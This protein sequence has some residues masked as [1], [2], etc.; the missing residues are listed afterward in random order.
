MATATR[1]GGFRPD[2]Y[3]P[4]A[5]DADNDGIVQEGTLFERPVGTRFINLDGTELAEM[6]S[7]TN[8][9]D[10]SGLKIVDRDGKTVDYKPSWSQGVLSIGQRF[11]SLEDRGLLSIGQLTGAVAPPKKAKKI[12]AKVSEITQTFSDSELAELR[13]LYPEIFDNEGNLIRPF[14][15]MERVYGFEGEAK[16]LIRG[17]KTWSDVREALRG[18]TII[19]YDYETT[20][21][22]SEGGRSVQ[23]GAVKIVDG[24]VVDRINIYMDPGI[25]HSQWSEFSRNNLRNAD[26]EIITPDMVA[27]WPSTQQ[28]HQ[29]FVDW[30][31][32]GEFYTMGHNAFTFDDRLQE[33]ELNSAGIEGFN[34]AGRLDTLSISRDLIDTKA[35][36][37]ISKRHT[38]GALAEA[39]GIELGDKA[40][41]ADAD[42]EATG[43]LLYALLDYAEDRDLPVDLIEPNKNEPR[44]QQM[45]EKYQEDKARY[46][47]LSRVYS[48]VQKSIDDRKRIQRESERMGVTPRPS[49]PQLVDETED[50]VNPEGMKPVRKS[51]DDIISGVDDGTISVSKV[52]DKSNLTIN[53]HG[54]DVEVPLY[55]DENGEIAE[56]SEEG[57]ELLDN[58]SKAGRSIRTRAQRL[59]MGTQEGKDILRNQDVLNSEERKRSLALTEAMNKSDKLTIDTAS[60]ILGRD[61]LSLDDLDDS[62]RSIILS[63]LNTDLT[64]DSQS[65]RLSQELREATQAYNEVMEQKYI[66]LMRIRALQKKAIVQI[67]YGRPN[68]DDGYTRRGNPDIEIPSTYR[69]FLPRS[70]SKEDR[71]LLQRRSQESIDDSIRYAMTLL[72]ESWQSRLIEEIGGTGSGKLQVRVFSPD[73]PRLGGAHAMFYK[74][75]DGSYIIAVSSNLT[76]PQ[77]PTQRRALRRVVGHE[78]MHA[79]EDAVPELAVVRDALFTKR[80]RETGVAGLR[81][82][83]DVSLMLDDDFSDTY[84]GVIYAGDD[85]HSEIFTTGFE[86]IFLPAETQLDVPAPDQ[87][88]SDIVLGV[89]ASISGKDR[90]G[91]LRERR[92]KNTPAANTPGD[93]PTPKLSPTVS[94]QDDR[95]S[96]IPDRSGKPLNISVPGSSEYYGV[97]PVGADGFGNPKH[98]ELSTFGAD[99]GQTIRGVPIDPDDPSIP[100]IL[101]H[102]SVD[103]PSVRREGTLRARGA[104]GLGGDSND[105]IVSMTVSSETAQQLESDM[106]LMTQI[107]RNVDNPDEYIRLLKDDMSKYGA[108]MS[109]KQ[110]GQIRAALESDPSGAYRMYFVTRESVGSKPRDPMFT[111]NATER[112]AEMDPDSIGI[113]QIPKENLKTGA[114]VTNFDVGEG[115]LDEIRIY[116]DVNTAGLEDVSLEDLREDPETVPVDQ[117]AKQI[118]D[119]DRALNNP[120]LDTPLLSDEGFVAMVQRIRQRSRDMRS[121]NTKLRGAVLSDGRIMSSKRS[122]TKD[123]KAQIASTVSAGRKVREK[124]SGLA[125]RNVAKTP[126]RDPKNHERDRILQASLEDV[127]RAERALL[128]ENEIK[129]LLSSLD[130]DMKSEDG[131]QLYAYFKENF[132]YLGISTA[133]RYGAY[134]FTT[135]PEESMAKF[136]TNL[137]GDLE[138]LIADF[139]DDKNWTDEDR[140]KVRDA[141]VRIGTAAGD[142]QYNT[143]IAKTSREAAVRKEIEDFHK[144]LGGSYTSTIIAAR[145]Q[146][147]IEVMREFDPTFGT[148]VLSFSNMTGLEDAIGSEMA[149]EVIEKAQSLVPK[150]WIDIV[151]DSYLNLIFTKRGYYSSST[152]EISLSNP[153]TANTVDG[154]VSTLIHEIG[155]VVTDPNKA[156]EYDSVKER[157]EMAFA[158]IASEHERLEQLTGSKFKETSISSLFPRSSYRADEKAGVPEGIG[159]NATEVYMLKIYPNV[160]QS[161]VDRSLGDQEVLSKFAELVFAGNFEAVEVSENGN[162]DVRDFA[163]GFLLLLQSGGI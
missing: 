116:G 33:I 27:S 80:A 12:E 16:E 126:W 87:E 95:R 79:M 55:L 125:A 157:M 98:R 120:D 147:M 25:P 111:D 64:Y 17:A 5:V 30:I 115:A 129:S 10:I 110:E 66:N 9:T 22:V 47:E 158:Y 42:S 77:N 143:F 32:D 119:M 134:S 140:Q 56:L 31:G 68:R 105:A 112:F 11:G 23:I 44:Y 75:P 70:M 8:L 13:S 67:L 94:A 146:A 49:T 113:V 153:H 130:I 83:D 91:A 62:E 35:E 48:A 90:P 7:G 51:V 148:G 20:G 50:I 19:A 38:L 152:R 76:D 29:Q 132:D 142:Y 108:T 82:H 14:N 123:G 57:E 109:D 28:A 154:L 160:V 88:H 58:I 85:I 93:T 159:L 89:L 106:R 2:P 37:A 69:F 149:R 78:I 65:R 155:H 103:A 61:I 72:P 41:T 59:W 163:V 60:R 102:V 52:A 1:W 84:S 74:G 124:L 45:A 81:E 144:S 156:S 40:H 15:P 86:R 24:E 131:Q 128:Y 92:L 136:R 122:L 118:L 63:A 135:D 121:R 96:S 43:K 139:G 18:K 150:E 138:K 3:N 161:I 53:S 4:D 97:K 21:F 114:M 99:R 101:Y 100:E 145:Q 133:P 107:S 26:G 54:S 141:L 137:M 104:G 46:E 39:F 117:L 71:D 6:I 127:G 34:P 36:D 73:S 151:N 162:Q